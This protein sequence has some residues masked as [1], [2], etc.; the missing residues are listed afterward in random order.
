MNLK[1]IKVIY[2]LNM[3]WRNRREI[4]K[5]KTQVFQNLNTFGFVKYIYSIKTYKQSCYH[6]L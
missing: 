6:E 3:L 1:N 2:K 4:D 5:V